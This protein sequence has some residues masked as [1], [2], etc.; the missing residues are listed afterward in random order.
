LPI[1]ISLK[2]L[3]I[4]ELIITLIVLA[5]AMTIFISN[6]SDGTR[7]AALA[8]GAMGILLFVRFISDEYFFTVAVGML[9]SAAL[10]VIGYYG[11]HGYIETTRFILNFLAFMVGL[12]AIYDSWYLFSLID[13]PSAKR[14]DDASRMSQEYGLPAR[15]WAL[16]WSVNAIIL[17]GVAL[18]LTFLF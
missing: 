14:T 18:W 5:G 15:F 13:N 1:C 9:T 17:L 2:K 7:W 12:N 3:H 8:V 6:D 16:L 11:Q 10:M 4:L